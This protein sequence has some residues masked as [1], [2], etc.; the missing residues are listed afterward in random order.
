MGDVLTGYSAETGATFTATVTEVSEYP[1]TGDSS[2]YWG[3]SGES[4]NQ[5]VSR[6]PFTAYIEDAENIIEG[7][8]SM[9]FVR[10]TKESTGIVIDAAFVRTDE[11]GREYVLKAGED[12]LLQKQIVS[13]TMAP[14]GSGLKIKNGL[15][16][17]DMIA[18]PYGK[19]VVEGARTV[20]AENF[21]SLYTGGFG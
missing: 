20:E 9:Q 3:F 6:Y 15:T 17:M 14:Y 4:K 2:S 19:G 10:K 12:G 11:Q 1:Q 21:D 13:T 8:A 7:T 5:N 16:E 18:F